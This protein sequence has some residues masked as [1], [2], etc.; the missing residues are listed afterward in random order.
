MYIN[1]HYT[2]L[3]TTLNSLFTSFN[4]WRRG[5]RSDFIVFKGFL[6]PLTV[7]S[8]GASAL[9]ACLN[10]LE[11]KYSYTLFLMQLPLPA[12][13]SVAEEMS[14]LLKVFLTCLLLHGFWCTVLFQAFCECHLFN[15]DWWEHTSVSA[16]AE[17]SAGQR[18]ELC[19]GREGCGMPLFPAPGGFLTWPGKSS[20]PHLQWTAAELR[21]FLATYACF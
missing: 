10:T 11:M 14:L 9:S 5:G 2:S 12:T 4:E 6:P 1:Q 17:A 19:S 18:W 3:D 16:S 15:F 21:T 7:Q 8:S 20:H 13:T